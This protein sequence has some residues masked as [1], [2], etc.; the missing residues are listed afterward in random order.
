MT[1]ATTGPIASE[2]AARRAFETT[3]IGVP[4]ARPPRE[5]EPL[6]AAVPVLL[7]AT[8]AAPA[9]ALF[10]EVLADLPPRAH[11]ARSELAPA[12]RNRD[13]AKPPRPADRARVLTVIPMLV[14]AAWLLSNLAFERNALDTSHAVAAAS[15]VVTPAQAPEAPPTDASSASDTEH[16]AQL[17]QSEDVPRSHPAEADGIAQAA[18]L[19]SQGNS[20]FDKGLLRTARARYLGAVNASPAYP[21]A[22]AG[23]SRLE[24]AR[25][26]AEQAVGYAERLVR[27]KPAPATYWVLLGDAY[28][29]AHMPGKAHEAWTRAMRR[30]S[31]IARLRLQRGRDS[32]DE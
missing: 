24:L 31:H 32:L 17:P 30:G 14:V 13:T 21:R 18:R 8:A 16:D 4:V 22:L 1:I 20:F 23:L 12:S 6:L 9:T 27:S 29:S 5:S 26:H 15:A 19:T 7:A 3:L 10:T 28:A 2:R 25:G 11:P